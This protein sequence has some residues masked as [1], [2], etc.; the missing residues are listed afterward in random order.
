VLVG[1]DA[2][3]LATTAN[4]LKVPY[5]IAPGNTTSEA[6]VASI[7][8]KAQEKFGGVDVVINTVASM[9]MNPT[10]G[11]IEPSKWF[12]DIVRLPQKLCAKGSVD[13]F[14]KRA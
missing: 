13:F 3:K 10:I 6:D 2:K 14:R 11:E 9:N 12:Y 7:F 4:E 5:L 1:R 8:Q